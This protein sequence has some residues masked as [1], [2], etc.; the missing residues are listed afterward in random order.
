MADIQESYPSPT[1]GIGKALFIKLTGKAVSNA[2]PQIG[3]G[4]LVGGNNTYKV[5]LSVANSNSATGVYGTVA[6]I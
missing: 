4:A 6:V 5:T 1:T 2:N 3:S